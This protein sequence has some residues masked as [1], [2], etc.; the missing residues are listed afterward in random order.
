MALS[1]FGCSNKAATSTNDAGTTDTSSNCKVITAGTYSASATGYHD[2]VKVEAT[3]DETGKISKLD[4]N[5]EGEIPKFGGEAAPKMADNIINSQRLDCDTISGA[6]LTSG[7]I[8][9]VNT[10]TPQI[11]HMVNHRK[12][13]IY[14]W[15]DLFSYEPTDIAETDV[16]HD[17]LKNAGLALRL[18][19]TATELL[20]DGMAL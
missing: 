6:S 2:E 11:S 7:A 13:K 16:V 10:E 18:E 4:V 1:M 5:A 14:H 15:F 3:V 19:T 9:H 8:F 12:W 20:K 17:N